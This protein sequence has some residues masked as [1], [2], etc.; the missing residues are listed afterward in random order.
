MINIYIDVLFLI[1]L[2]IN[3]LIVEA[4]GLIVG[5]ECR[6]YRTLI[7]AS[8]GAIYSVLVF[9]PDLKVLL[10]LVMKI[11]ISGVMVVCGFKIRNKRSFFK[12]WGSFY[13]VSFIFG[14]ALIGI[15]SMTD[16]GAKTGAVYSNGTIYLNLPWQL[17]FACSAGAYFLIGI[18]SRVRRR[19]ILRDRIGRNL[20]IYINGKRCDMKA[21]IDTGNT[22]SDPITGMPVIVCEYDEIKGILPFAEGEDLVERMTEAKMKVR[23]IPFTSVGTQKGLMPAF[24]PDRV[25]IDSF[26]AKKCIVGISEG[27]LSD[28]E[29]YHALLN[30]M[31]IIN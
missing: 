5:E 1:N 4:T 20:S 24:M 13:M 8:V 29:D 18:F 22:L 25:K 2:I 3:I 30:P 7:S 21:I 16:L 10:S 14:G 15:M 28:N 9:F 19:K 11:A 17:L 23:L 12:L 6:W 31:L 27:K 26:E